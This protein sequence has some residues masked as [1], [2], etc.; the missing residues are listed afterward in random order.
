M[1]EDDRKLEKEAKVRTK[2]DT[3]MSSRDATDGE[4]PRVLEDG[5][6]PLQSIYGGLKSAKKRKRE[7]GEHGG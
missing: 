4:S 3:S 5:T 7:T 6:K 2:T 1:D